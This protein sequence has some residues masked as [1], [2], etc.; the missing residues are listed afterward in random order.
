MDFSSAF[1]VSMATLWVVAQRKGKTTRTAKGRGPGL[2]DAQALLELGEGGGE[3]GVGR[4]EVLYLAIELLLDGGEL[5][6]GEGGEVDCGCVSE[7]VPRGGMVGQL[8]WRM[9]PTAFGAGLG[10]E[11]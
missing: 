3:L 6:G 1:F 7:G 11:E 8:Q 2:D 9:I 10:A 5:L 4:R